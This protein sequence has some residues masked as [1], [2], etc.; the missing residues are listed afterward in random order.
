MPSQIPADDPGAVRAALVSHLTRKLAPLYRSGQLRAE[1]AEWL[2]PL[3]TVTIMRALDGD[4]EK[5]AE[6]L[7][8]ALVQDSARRHPEHAIADVIALEHP[9]LAAGERALLIG[10]TEA[11]RQLAHEND[12]TVTERDLF[13]K[14]YGVQTQKRL[15]G[16]AT[17]VL[18]ILDGHAPMR[19]RVDARSSERLL[20]AGVRASAR[21][22]PAAAVPA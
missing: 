8:V 12:G 19:K 3:P 17:Q 20:E 4:P 2:A 13:G 1:L 14:G 18:A 11:L 10:F 7:A 5:T 6:A 22:F 9:K 15:I 21:L 16:T